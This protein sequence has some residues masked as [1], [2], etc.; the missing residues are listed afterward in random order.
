MIPM[1]EA[2]AR[3]AAHTFAG[4]VQRLAALSS[5]DIYRAYGRFTGLEPGPVETGLDG[6][7]QLRTSNLRRAKNASDC[8]INRTARAGAA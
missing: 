6:S 5:G 2:D 8:R 3:T 7:S 1:G 4:R